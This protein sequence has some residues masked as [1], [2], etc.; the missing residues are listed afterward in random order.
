MINM[1][2]RP[3]RR[4]SDGLEKPHRLRDWPA[5]IGAVTAGF[6]K[7]LFYIF[8]LVWE[9]APLMLILMMLFCIVDGILPVVGAYISK[10]ILNVIADLI[11]ASD[12]GSI[13]DDILVVMEPLVWLMIA[14]FIYLFLK[15]IITRLNSMVTSI[16][17]ELVVNHIK[18]KII[19]KA[20]EVDLASYD[21]PEFYE[22][23]ENANREAGMR[24][25]HILSATF[26]LV[27]YLISTVSFV[28]VLAT[29][30]PIAPVIIVC[31]AVP[32]AIVNYIY[33]NKNYGYI[34]RHSKERRA[35][36]Y[37]SMLMATR[38]MAKEIRILGLGDTFTSKY[39]AVFKKYYEGLRRLVIREGVMQIFVGLIST[40]VSCALF[41]Y[42]AYNVVFG[43]GEIGDY[44]LYTGAL[45]SIATY[46]T[47]LLS[48][49]STIYEGT[50]FI[51]NMMDFMNEQPHVVPLLTEPRRVERGVRHTVELRG[52]SFR[53][54]G[55]DK[56]VIDNLSLK[57][58]TPDSVVLVGLN[59]AGKTTLIKLLTRLYDPTEG[60][61]LF[62]GHDIREYD[63]KD[64]YDLFGIIFQDFGKYAE[65]ARENI[66]FGDARRECD[67][68]AVVS[69]AVSADADGFIKELPHGYDTPLT[70]MFE[71]DGIEL[72]GGQWQKLSVAR[73]FYK[74]SD[75][76]ILDEPTASLDA[77][78]EKEIFDR[79]AELSVDKLTIFVSHRLSSAVGASKIVVLDSGRVVETGTHEELMTLGGKDCELFTTQAKRYIESETK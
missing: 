61:I 71:D 31:A 10:D 54:P 22:K 28:A 56:N 55:T 76:L 79:F 60:V 1:P 5:Y 45:T 69:A 57:L 64:I 50:L 41:V 11:G 78:A 51:N 14:Y 46:V 42:I 25:L 7:R 30:T 34:R 58:E 73:A 19:L 66:S 9:S 21:R 36:N 24:P 53:Y 74:N 77:I 18:L 26:S 70:R 8:T 48:S 2:P 15:K 37:Y 20:R 44:S 32:G 62:D 29:L 27:S 16:A 68:A 72:S 17:G 13:K 67:E 6:F 43:N 75:I 47:Y 3:P 4:L 49:T 39:K 40:V 38:D 33:R 52:V 35:M 12:T 65:S 59:G 23:L 63:P